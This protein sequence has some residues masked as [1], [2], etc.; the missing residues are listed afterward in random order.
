MR[1]AAPGQKAED[2]GLHDSAHRALYRVATRAFN[3]VAGLAIGEE[4]GYVRGK[5]RLLDLVEARL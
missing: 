2:T 1:T 3:E 4:D 5:G